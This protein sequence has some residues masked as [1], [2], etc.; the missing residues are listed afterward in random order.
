MMVPPPAADRPLHFDAAYAE[1]VT[2]RDGSA[3][4]LRL[5]RP[6][7]GPL[8]IAGFKGLSPRSRFRRFLTDKG[9]LVPRDL[10][11]LT[12]IDQY[13]HF[14]LG[15]LRSLPG[16]PGDG[17]GIARFIRL[18]HRP[19][20]A[21]AAVAVIDSMQ[22]KGLGR[23]LLVR[24]AAAARERGIE[25]FY[26]EVLE[27]N[28]PIQ[29]LLHELGLVTLPAAEEGVFSVEIPLSDLRREAA[30]AGLL[31]SMSSPS[32]MLERFLAA[33]AAGLLLVRRAVERW[34]PDRAGTPGTDSRPKSG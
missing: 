23:I 14:A 19:E 32:S 3:A 26:C 2:L 10:S 30:P 11:Y 18:R 1:R 28:L 22:R 6:T 5:V 13:D 25:R 4:W 9:E 31:P 7:D 21:E 27:T 15:A 16:Q 24:L 12:Q 33:A 29:R 34:A 17:L 8:L 20:V